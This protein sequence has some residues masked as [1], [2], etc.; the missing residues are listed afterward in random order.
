MPGSELAA[1]GS[2]HWSRL[3]SEVGPAKSNEEV[4][5]L[6]IPRRQGLSHK[7]RCTHTCEVRG[8]PRGR[9]PVPLPKLHLEFPSLLESKVAEWRRQNGLTDCSRQVISLFWGCWVVVILY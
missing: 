1:S 5:T 6:L 3:S 2:G 7:D 9:E 8:E 4:S